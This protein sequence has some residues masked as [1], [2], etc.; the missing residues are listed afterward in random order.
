MLKIKYIRFDDDT[1]AVFAGDLWHDS[2]T[3]GKVAVSAGFICTGDDLQCVGAS[4]SLGL[5]SQK[6]DTGMLHKW[7]GMVELCR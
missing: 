1:F 4:D 5:S 3:G 7:L 6:E 2:M